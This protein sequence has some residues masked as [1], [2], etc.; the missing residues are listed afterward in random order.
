MDNES[1]KS[2]GQLSIDRLF[3]ADEIGISLPEPHP[4]RAIRIFLD[5]ASPAECEAVAA[6]SIHMPK[7]VLLLETPRDNPAG[8]AIYIYD[9]EAGEFYIVSFDGD[10]ADHLT[11]RQFEDLVGEYDLLRYAS[12]PAL[13]K[14]PVQTSGTA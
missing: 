11:V 10:P 6:R 5:L 8:G 7:G 3:T 2:R 13:M 4:D 1:S 9:R 12:C 14:A